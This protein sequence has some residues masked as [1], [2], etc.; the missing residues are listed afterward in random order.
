[1]SDTPVNTLSALVGRWK[2]VLISLG[3]AVAAYITVGAVYL[4]PRAALL[5][6]RSDLRAA[7]AN[8]QKQMPSERS[9]RERR[10]KL[11]SGLL[12]PSLDQLSAQ[13]RDGLVRLGEQS[14]L[15]GVVVEHGAPQDQVSPLVNAKG[16]PTD[17]K[18]ELRKSPDFQVVRGR[19]RGTGTLAEALTALARAQ[20]QPWIHRVE[21]FSL[22]PVGKDRAEVELRLDIATVYAP[23]LAAKSVTPTLEPPS[24]RLAG[25]VRALESRHW[26]KAPADKQ[27]DVPDVLLAAASTPPPAR[28]FA[29]YEDWMLTGLFR[30]RHGSEALFVNKKTGSKVTVPKGGAVLDAVFID[31]AGERAIV[32]IAGQRFE[33]TSGQTLASR[34]PAG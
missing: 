15:A 18:R 1:M 32:E 34:K 26:F 25:M 27:P 8:L 11:A 20:E 14:G 16:I 13:L 6:Q 12:G 33:V 5:S 31:G 23:A 3:L 28:A 24:D 10:T 30:G 4:K 22:K 29:P 7:V 9:L 21:G 17:L 19:M 2:V